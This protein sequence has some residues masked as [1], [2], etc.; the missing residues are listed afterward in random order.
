MCGPRHPAVCCMLMRS[1][2]NGPALAFG[3]RVLLAVR[4]GSGPLRGRKLRA[5]GLCQTDACGVRPRL[6]EQRRQLALRL[7]RGQQLREG[8]HEG[9]ASLS[10][11]PE[12]SARLTA[13]LCHHVTFAGECTGVDT[14]LAAVPRS[15]SQLL[16]S[17]TFVVGSAAHPKKRRDSTTQ[18]SGNWPARHG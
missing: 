5:G 2:P 8:P 12:Q 14:Q 15:V 1:A 17:S 3:L 10:H 4:L 6:T 13:T 7:P 9:E 18:R 16:L 11:L